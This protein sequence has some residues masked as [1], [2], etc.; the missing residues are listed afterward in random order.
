MNYELVYMLEDQ[1]TTIQYP[2]YT[3]SKHRWISCTDLFA[4]RLGLDPKMLAK[5][6]NISSGRSWCTEL[7]NPCPGVIDGVP[8]SNKYQGGFGTALMNKVC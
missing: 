6:L 3:I 5:I 4:F 1:S 8:S 7:Y 2:D